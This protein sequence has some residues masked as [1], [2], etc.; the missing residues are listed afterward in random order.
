MWAGPKS[1]GLWY[2]HHMPSGFGVRVGSAVPGQ[3]SPMQ[4]TACELVEWLL[5]YDHAK[6]APRYMV[7]SVYLG[8]YLSDGDIVWLDGCGIG[9]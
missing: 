1:R 4:Q 5:C 8:A 7:F 2:L 3:H 9:R 6:G